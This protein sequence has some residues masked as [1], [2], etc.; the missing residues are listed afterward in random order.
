MQKKIEEAQKTEKENV[1]DYKKELEELK[2]EKEERAKSRRLR[3]WVWTLNNPTVEEIEYIRTNTANIADFVCFQGEYGE[4]THTPHLQGYIEL[5]EGKTMSVVKKKYL[6]TKRAHLIERRAKINTDAIHY[7]KK[8]CDEPDCK[9]SYCLKLKEKVSSGEISLKDVRWLNYEEYGTPKKPTNG[10]HYEDLWA[11]LK[12]GMTPEEILDENASYIPVYNIITKLHSKLD[13]RKWETKKIKRQVCWIYGNPG[14]G[15]T[16]WVLNHEKSLFQVKEKDKNRWDLY[17]G[18]EAILFD[19]FQGKLEI[20]DMNALLHEHPAPLKARYNN[21]Y[22][23]ASRIYIVTNQ[24]PYNFYP[25]DE[26]MMRESLFRRIHIIARANDKFE[27]VEDI[28]SQICSY[29]DIQTANLSEHYR[30]DCNNAVEIEFV[31]S[32]SGGGYS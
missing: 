22:L 28:S 1:I 8:P 9:K 7:C 11:L 2:E 16:T 14:T 12:E 25:L 19:E 4:K 27:L 20:Q 32:Q 30:F 31:K 29:K 26:P 13:A 5:P 17:S 21:K 18:Q 6:G 24:H 10:K 23:K 3:T 15:K